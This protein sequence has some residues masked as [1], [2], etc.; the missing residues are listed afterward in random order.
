MRRWRMAGV[1]VLVLG[2]ASA[3]VVYWLGTRTANLADDPSMAGFFKAE[4]RQM[5]LLYGQQGILMEGLMNDLKQPETQAVLIV[6]AAV[7]LFRLY[8]VLGRRTGNERPPQESYRLLESLILSKYIL[9]RHN[10][11]IFLLFS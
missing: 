6:V 10:Y 7:I 8:T 5:G 3:G 1:F 4:S 11:C 2:L 9:D